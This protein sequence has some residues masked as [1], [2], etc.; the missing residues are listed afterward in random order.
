M[1]STR[2]PLVPASGGAS[3]DLVMFAEDEEALMR[4]VFVHLGTRHK[5][6][7]PNALALSSSR[8]QELAN[9]YFGFNGWS[10]RIIKSLQ[11]QI[12]TAAVSKFVLWGISEKN[13]SK[14]YCVQRAD[15]DRLVPFHTECSIQLFFFDYL[16]YTGWSVL[17][18]KAVWPREEECLSDFSL[19]EEEFRLPELE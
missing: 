9:Y 7:Q 11:S 3:R 19:E 2:R 18:F 8:C 5:A 17:F 1:N 12:F 13:D 14:Y 6:F 15:A 16:P 10:K 4:K